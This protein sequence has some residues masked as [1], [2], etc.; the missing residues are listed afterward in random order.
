MMAMM[1]FGR[2]ATTPVAMASYGGMAAHPSMSELG[3]ARI[4]NV[5]RTMTVDMSRQQAMNYGTFRHLEDFK[6]RIFYIYRS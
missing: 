4:H 5:Q 2:R 6:I 3:A 1:A